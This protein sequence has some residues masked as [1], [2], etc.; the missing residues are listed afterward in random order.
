MITLAAALAPGLAPGAGGVPWQFGEPLTIAPAGEGVFHHLE[1]AGSRNIA[2]GGDVVAIVWE[3]NRSGTPQIYIAQLDVGE[4]DVSEPLRV[5][6]GEAAYEPAIAAV[7]DGQF[8]I[9]W[10]QDDAVWVRGLAEQRLGDPQ[11]LAGAI[12]AQASLAADGRRAVAVWSERRGNASHIGLREMVWRGIDKPIELHTP[13]WVDI[14][15]PDAEQTYPAVVL[16][17]RSVLVAWEDRRHGHTAL[18]VAHA[19][20]GGKFTAP[21]PLNEQPPQR[22]AVYG[23]G[24]GAARPVLTR[25]GRRGAAAVWLDKRDFTSGYDVYAGLSEDSS[26]GFGRNE[27]VQDEFG[28]AISQWHATAAGDTNGNLVATWSDNRDDTPDLWFAWRTAQ[29][30]SG[31]HTVPGAAGAGEQTHPAVAFDRR[32]GMHMAWVDRL[33]GQGPTSI[34]YLYARR[35]PTAIEKEF[36][37]SKISPSL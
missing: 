2:V 29:G 31:D 25:W 5:S 8:I 18:L 14:A 20:D 16:H 27:K 30:W 26:R 12:S 19:A 34:R 36:P 9:A 32:G 35:T 6:T 13:Q 10:E 28:N 17:R 4:P 21:Q 37:S 23:K 1:S 7:G 33:Q 15:P 11:R 3:D 24:T 22:S